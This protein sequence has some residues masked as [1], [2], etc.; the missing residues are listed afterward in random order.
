MLVSVSSTGSLLINLL[1]FVANLKKNM[2]GNFEH[3]NVMCDDRK[4]TKRYNVL[5][6]GA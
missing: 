6:L 1:E 4:Y 2:L 5:K 3:E